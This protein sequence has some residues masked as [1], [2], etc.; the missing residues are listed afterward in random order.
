MKI[1][2]INDAGYNFTADI[3]NNNKPYET[4]TRDVFKSMIPAA[5]EKILIASTGRTSRP[6]LIGSAIIRPGF[7]PD[8]QQWKSIRKTARIAGTKYDS[9]RPKWCYKLDNPQPLPQP[10]PLP[11]N[12][13]RHGRTWCEYVEN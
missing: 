10:V 4:R 12:V 13:I 1:I 11:T 2:Y 3:M 7:I 5:G 8:L 9:F 6:V